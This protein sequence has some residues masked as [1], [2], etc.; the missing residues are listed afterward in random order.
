MVGIHVYDTDKVK[1]K[2]MNIVAESHFNERCDSA[3]RI[4]TKRYG[5]TAVSRGSDKLAILY[6]GSNQIRYAAATDTSV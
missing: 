6:D 3:T 4:S 2:H 5:V 1:N